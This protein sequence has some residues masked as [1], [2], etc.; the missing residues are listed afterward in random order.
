MTYDLLMAIGILFLF[1]ALAGVCYLAATPTPQKPAPLPRGA[2]F[3]WWLAERATCPG[4][5]IVHDDGTI[6]GCTEDDEPHGCAGRDEPHDDGA[7]RCI[8]W[9]EDG[10]DY[11]GV[12][13]DR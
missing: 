7:V 4:T 11:C 9:F 3:G 1:L 12:H 6:A 5:L 13:S 10:C 8:E 2:R